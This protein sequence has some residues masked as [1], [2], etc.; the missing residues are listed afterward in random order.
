M[1]NPPL[2]TAGFGVSP[3]RCIRGRQEKTSVGHK[4]PPLSGNG[5]WP[6]ALARHHSPTA[7]KFEVFG[8]F[9][10]NSQNLPTFSWIENH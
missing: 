1:Q 7:L 3:T 6:V 2:S 8:G 9:R 5:G 10:D 4:K